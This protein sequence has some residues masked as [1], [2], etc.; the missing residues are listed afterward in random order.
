M[1][2]KNGGEKMTEFFEREFKKYHEGFINQ[3]LQESIDEINGH[4]EY[5]IEY[6]KEKGK[7]YMRYL[8][9][10]GGPNISINFYADDITYFFAWF[11][12]HREVSIKGTQNY[13]DL[14]E[15]YGYE[16]KEDIEIQI[17][18]LEIEY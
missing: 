6:N 17:D 9:G 14:W 4:M 15:L 12:T 16:A 2:T 13:D 18:T 10:F 3:S 5:S 11:P 1:L 7:P 8:V